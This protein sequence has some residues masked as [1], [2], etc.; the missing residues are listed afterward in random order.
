[1]GVFFRKR[2]LEKYCVGMLFMY[3]CVS[4]RDKLGQSK[5]NNW[6]RGSYHLFCDMKYCFS[7]SPVFTEDIHQRFE[8]RSPVFVL[9]FEAWAFQILKMSSTPQIATYSLTLFLLRQTYLQSSVM[10]TALDL[11]SSHRCTVRRY[12]CNFSEV[13]I[14]RMIR[15]V[16]FCMFQDESQ[17]FQIISVYAQPNYSV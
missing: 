16:I 3:N 8:S 6:K 11:S 14:L 5:C 1:M 10:I 2:V 7:I 12:V 15:W 13:W 9:R 17:Q 4:S